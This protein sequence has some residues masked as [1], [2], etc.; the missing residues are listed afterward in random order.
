MSLLKLDK[1]LI[2]FIAIII[3][4]IPSVLTLLNSGFFQTDDGN[5][6]VIRFSAFYESLRDGQFPVRYLSRLNNGYGYPV[7]N[8]LYPLFMY[9]GTPIHAIGISFV[10]TIKIILGASL[11]LSSIFCF[12]W[13]RKKFDNLSS[14]IG[15]VLYLYFPYHLWDVYK[16]GSVGEVLA[17]AIVPFIFLQIERNSLFWGAIGIASLILSHNTIALLSLPVIIIYVGIKVWDSKN[18]ILKIYQY[19]SILVLGIGL[20][21]FFSVPAVFDLQYT[22]FFQTSISDWSKYF[23]DWELIG[24][25]SIIVFMAFFLLFIMKV[26]TIQKHRL[27]VFF[28]IVGVF[29][30]FFAGSLSAFFWHLLPIASF[31]QF[32]F[33]FLS[34]A[35]FCVSF[36]G[37][38]IVSITSREK[39]TIVVVLILIF[40]ALSSKSFI[41][42]EVF[43]NYPD[44]FYS[45]NMDTTTV[46]NEY[47][48]KWVKRVPL[49]MSKEK[50][51]II[52]GKGEISS[53]IADGNKYNFNLT[54]RQD[55]VV[56]INTVYFPGWV[57]K[58]ND[59]SSPII[60]E[61]NGLLR[62]KA[63]EG[64]H[65]V[66]A[67][68]TET[69]VRLLSDVISS[70]SLIIILFSLLNKKRK[71]LQI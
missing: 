52:T 7:S 29:S 35:M 70:G 28:F 11:V 21:A 14:L 9:I 61:E 71:I 27:T 23:A 3:L 60:Y 13:L 59:K 2:L 36:L 58:I 43:Q 6:M 68:F 1:K 42:P 10:D 26:S 46:K 19:T 32:P 25:S 54:L 15:S 30:I 34:L 4:S 55:S 17:L 49:Q 39:K 45:T 66:V 62:F 31:I 16:R 22:V 44:A 56:Q 64:N 57:L 50:I 18:K 51:E 8:F 33:R 24:I 47:M 48:P 37:A 20:S 65:K 41:Y 40:T 53:L 38:F 5:W 63:S 12:L 69:K 67:K